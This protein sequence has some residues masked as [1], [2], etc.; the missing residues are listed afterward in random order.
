M[1]AYE[2][3][4]LRYSLPAGGAVERH[5][6]VSVN[7]KSAGIQAT[8][9]TEVIGVSMNKTKEGEVLEIADGIVMVTAA[10]AI[11]AGK[12]IIIVYNKWDLVDKDHTTM[13]KITKHIRTQLPYLDYAPIVF[14]SALNKQRVQNL[15]PLIDEVYDYSKFR[16]ST[17]L[18]NE[19]ISDAQITTPPPT[20]NGKRLKINFASQIK[21]APPTFAVFVNDENLLHFSYSRYLE[22]KL[23]EA[24]EFTGNPIKIIARKK[25]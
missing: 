9:S 5:R 21:V 13:D 15:F 6:F 24:F 17:S 7:N 16:V 4:G 19:V 2:I 1:N 10:A 12:G 20:H 22:N 8:A 3:P 25:N 14:V 23:R 18:L 11:E